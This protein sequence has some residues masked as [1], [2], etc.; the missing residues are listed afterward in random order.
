MNT[1]NLS[2]YEA[3]MNSLENGMSID[4]LFKEFSKA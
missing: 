2:I 1:N 4:E 3:M